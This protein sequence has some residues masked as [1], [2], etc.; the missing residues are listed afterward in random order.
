MNEISRSYI[1]QAHN[2]DPSKL[3]PHPQVTASLY[4]STIEVDEKLKEILERLNYDNLI[5]LSSCQYNNL[6]YSS[7]SFDYFEFYRLMIHIRVKHYQKYGNAEDY[8][9]DS[10]WCAI[11]M[12]NDDTYWWNSLCRFTTLVGEYDEGEKGAFDGN[13]SVSMHIYP[14][15]VGVFVKLWDQLFQVKKE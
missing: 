14:E 12:N 9:Q 15:H 13:I 5:T 6:G 3:A 1:S 11:A 10:L 7:I 4:R 8:H 2:Y